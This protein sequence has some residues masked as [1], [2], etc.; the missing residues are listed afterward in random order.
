VC[1]FHLDQSTPGR[2][3][4][5][6]MFNLGV[7]ESANSV[8]V[9]PRHTDIGNVREYTVIVGTNLS[10]QVLRVTFVHLDHDP[11]KHLPQFVKESLAIQSARDDAFFVSACMLSS[12]YCVIVLINDANINWLCVNQ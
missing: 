8:L 2:V 10:L 3:D 4:Y 11:S 5:H 7:G 12:P 9:L 1:V 6:A